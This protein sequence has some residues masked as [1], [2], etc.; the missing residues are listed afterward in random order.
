MSDWIEGEPT[1][2]GLFACVVIEGSIALGFLPSSKLLWRCGTKTFWPKG[3]LSGPS[4]QWFGTKILRHYR[5]HEPTRAIEDAVI[6]L[7]QEHGPFLT[8]QKDEVRSIIAAAVAKACEERDR[9][10]RLE[11]AVRDERWNPF[12][13]IRPI[14][15]GKKLEL[16]WQVW[17]FKNDWYPSIQADSKLVVYD[18]DSPEAAA[19]AALAQEDEP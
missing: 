10:D 17:D 6:A 11:R 19:Q 16:R 18:A 4:H 1:E 12:W 3:D 9:D 14:L 7:E 2:D 5:L 15:V 13:F 8:S